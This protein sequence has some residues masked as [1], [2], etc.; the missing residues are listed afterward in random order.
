MNDGSDIVNNVTSLPPLPRLVAD[1]QIN[2]QVPGHQYAVLIDLGGSQGTF[3]VFFH[4]YE[5]VQ[6]IIHEYRR[7]Y[8][9]TVWPLHNGRRMG[10]C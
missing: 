1:H 5:P 8:P 9:L 2:R 6:R 10:V 7:K 3:L 4:R